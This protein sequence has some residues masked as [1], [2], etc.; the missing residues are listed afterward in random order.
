MNLIMDLIL[1]LR[2]DLQL[3]IVFRVTLNS[4]VNED[5]RAIYLFFYEDILHTHKSLI[6]T[7]ATFTQIFL[8]A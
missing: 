4:I 5:I 1:D 7:Q 8:Y 6:S 2:G 3:F